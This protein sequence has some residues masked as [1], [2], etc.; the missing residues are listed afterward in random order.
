MIHLTLYKKEWK[1]NGILLLIFLAVL[2]MYAV[3]IVSMFDPAMGDSLRFLAESMPELFAAFGMAD[4]GTTLL[5][6]VTGYLYGMLFVAFPGVFLIILA[7]RLIARYVD[8]GSMVYLLSAP[9]KRRRI[10]VTQAFFLITALAAMVIYVTVLILIVSQILFPGDLAT[11][12]FLR[13]NAGLFGLLLFFG[14]ACFLASCIFNESKNALGIGTAVVVYSILVQMI[15]QVGDKFEN[16]K[17]LTPVTLFDI[18]GLAAAQSSAWFSCGILYIG[19]I[20]LIVLGILLFE[21][22]DLPI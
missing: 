15:S 7:N 20:L 16:L 5:E 14:G 19:G 3:M 10:A 12:A 9:V 6:F 8:Q 18:D 21:R 11:A 17:Y 1:S 13:V 2:T 4:V 22:R